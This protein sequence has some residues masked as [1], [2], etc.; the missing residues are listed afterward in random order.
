MVPDVVAA[1]KHYIVSYFGKGLYGIVLENKTIFT[2][3]VV[4]N[5]SFRTDIANEAVAF[6]LAFLIHLCAKGVH[7]PSGHACKQG[8]TAWRVVFCQRVKVPYR[9]V[10]KTVCFAVF[11]MHG[12][13]HCFII[14][15][16]GK[17]VMR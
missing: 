6:L 5:G 12:K 9:Q 13:G 16:M 15:V 3:G 1:P 17:V 10:F 11:C 7:F 4:K 14:A 8:I 2:Y